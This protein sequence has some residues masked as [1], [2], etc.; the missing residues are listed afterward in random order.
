MTDSKYK[1]SFTTGGLFYREATKIVE[2]Y[3]QLRDWAHVRAQIHNENLLKTRTQSSLKRTARE[4]VQ[5][6]E[7]LTDDQLTILVD[8]SRQEQNQILW[9]AVCKQYSFVREFA[10]EVVREKFL[11]LDLEL[12]YRDFDIFFN[13]KAE[14][15][16]ILDQTKE[17]TRKKMRQVL[18]RILAEAEIILPGGMIVPVMLSPRVARAVCDDD[19]SFL[20]VFP[21]SEIDMRMY[22]NDGR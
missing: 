1:I 2:L 12:S 6:M 4:L 11:R 20:A 19:A 16:E 8:G 14:W 21:I 15:N 22:K 9:L 10:I 5:R 18:F 3:F 13:R 17:S 7:V